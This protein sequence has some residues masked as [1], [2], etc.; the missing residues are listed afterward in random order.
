MSLLE[1]EFSGYN[2]RIRLLASKRS[3]I[4]D[5]RTSCVSHQ[6]CIPLPYIKEGRTPACKGLLG[7]FHAIMIPLSELS[8]THFSA[9]ISCNFLKLT[10]LSSACTQWLPSSA[11]W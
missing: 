1:V 7:L 8:A 5:D 2:P 4:S 10:S 9:G 6:L 11:I 3:L